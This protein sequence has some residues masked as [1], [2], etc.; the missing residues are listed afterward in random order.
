VPIGRHAEPMILRSE[1][2]HRAFT[3]VSITVGACEELTVP[4]PHTLT[5]P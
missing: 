4:S 3:H 1:A 5:E 2:E